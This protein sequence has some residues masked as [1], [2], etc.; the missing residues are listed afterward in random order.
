MPRWRQCSKTGN[1]IPIDHSAVVSD[2]K[3]D[4]V[5]IKGNFEAFVS[6]IDGK[7]ISNQKRL[8]EHNRVHGVVDSREFSQEYYDRKAKERAKIYNGEHTVR[9]SFERKVE[10]NSIIE[11]LQNGRK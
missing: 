7:V 3:K 10:I 1:L 8:E 2:A 11:R 4:G 5:I 9:E 6:P